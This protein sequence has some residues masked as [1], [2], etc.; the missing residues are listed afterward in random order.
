MGVVIDWVRVGVLVPVMSIQPACCV[1][2]YKCFTHLFIDQRVPDIVVHH[3]YY[4]H[5]M[6][7]LVHVL[8]S[9][10]TTVEP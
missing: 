2:C 1:F 5:I 6:S 7:V 10:S 8:D 9:F 3:D 4:D